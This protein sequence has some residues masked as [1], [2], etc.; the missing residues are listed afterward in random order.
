MSFAF[1][2]G[3][4]AKKS[5]L[6]AK[7][8]CDILRHLM[9]LQPA[10]ALNFLRTTLKGFSFFPVLFVTGF[11][12]SFNYITVDICLLHHPVLWTVL[13]FHCEEWLEAISEPKIVIQAWLTSKIFTCGNNIYYS[14]HVSAV[15]WVFSALDP[16]VECATLSSLR[17]TTSAQT[18]GVTC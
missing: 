6:G 14:Y 9:A 8:V 17:S 16:S 18:S 15:P 1:K 5:Q 12:L 4:R 10:R 3:V 7:N 2:R 13:Q 11:I